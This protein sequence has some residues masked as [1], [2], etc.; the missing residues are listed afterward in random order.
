M[1]L[2]ESQV[3]PCR[4]INADVM[5]GLRALPDESVHCVVTSPPYWCLRDYG[6]EGQIGLERTIE[7][8]IARMVEVFRDVRRVLRGDGVCW[9]NLGDSYFSSREHACDKDGRESPG[10]LD[11]D[12]P[13]IHLCDECRDSLSFRIVDIATRRVL[14]SGAYGG[15]PIRDHMGKLSPSLENWGSSIRSQNGQLS[16][17]KPGQSQEKDPERAHLCVSVESMID[18]SSPQPPGG[19]WHCANC[20]VCLSVLGSSTRDA[21]QCARMEPR[22]LG[23]A[24]RA[25]VGRNLDRGVLV[26]AYRDSTIASL[27]SK[28]LVGIPWRVAFALQADGWYLRSDIIWAKPNPM[29]ESV[30]DRPTKSHEYIF[31]LSK[32]ERYYYDTNA[33]K[34]S[35]SQPQTDY[36]MPDG[37]DT[38]AGAHGSFHRNGREKG[39]KPDKQRGHGRRHAGF[40]ERWDSMPRAEQCGGMRNKRSVWIIA[41]QPFTGWAK[42]CRRVSVAR[43]DADGDTKRIASPNCPVHASLDHLQTKGACGEREADALIRT[44]GSD[45]HHGQEPQGAHESTAP[46]RDVDSAEQSLDSPY[47]GCFSSA[48]PHSRQSRRMAHGHATNPSCK[49]SG[50]IPL[51]TQHKSA[52]SER[53]A[54]GGRTPENKNAPDD[55]GDP[56]LEQKTWRTTDKPSSKIP[57]DCRCEFYRE[58]RVEVSHFATFPTKL[59]E[60]C[61]LA[62]S[63]EGC[64][65]LDP[66]GGSGT[67]G[68]VA[69]LFGRQS[70]LIE[71]NPEYV[72][73]AEARVGRAV[74]KM[75]FLIPQS[76]G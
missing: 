73:L 34:E 61:I 48:T 66:F 8:Y 75:G 44:H 9:I 39:Q 13:S 14:L 46:S 30:T 64:V 65:V 27:K 43:D 50:E 6:I 16:R 18:E 1:S 35:A 76:K 47:L 53:N 68:E 36:K 42:T 32:S 24:G 12:C 60:P 4:I 28:D 19:C 58:E 57:P 26:S 56:L 17:A 3:G 2:T 38:G 54:H 11:D 7:E 71:L 25:S 45:V 20:A 49:P 69:T 5:D 10:C 63:P 37:W 74:E 55:S 23:I 21:R 40:N 70:I 31:L 22:S 15:G 33:I 51:R 62:G 52:L 67:V 59:V 41:T 29:P 72:K